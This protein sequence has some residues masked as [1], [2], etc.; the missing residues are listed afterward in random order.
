MKHIL[1][2]SLIGLAVFLSEAQ[3]QVVFGKIDSTLKIGKAGY[4]VECKN[5]RFDLENPK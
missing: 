2:F 5:K 3:A 1:I 4:R